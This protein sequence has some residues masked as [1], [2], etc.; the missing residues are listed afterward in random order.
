MDTRPGY[1]N[2][3]VDIILREKTKREKV[4]AGQGTLS[5]EEGIKENIRRI[6]VKECLREKEEERQKTKSMKERED[7]LIRNGRL[8]K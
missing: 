8:C 6:L 4:K 7:Y 1:T 5:F 2:P 3:R